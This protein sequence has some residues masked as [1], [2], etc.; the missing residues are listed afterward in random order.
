[1]KKF[2]VPS[3]AVGVQNSDGLV[4][5]SLAE[6]VAALAKRYGRTLSLADLR[7]AYSFDQDVSIA[8]ALSAMRVLGLHGD[9]KKPA[10]I[11]VENLP[12]IAKFKNGVHVV[13]IAQTRR[14]TEFI[15]T[16]K[17]DALSRMKTREFKK[18]F[19]GVTITASLDL[20]DLQRRHT[21]VSQ[22][23]HWFWGRF[24][25]QG[26]NIRAII[27][28]TFV[29]NLLAVGVSLF[30]LQVYDRVIPN[31]SQETL[32]V[33]V[34]GAII[35]ILFEAVLRIARSN[36]V[37]V[38]GRKLENELNETLFKRLVGMKL[39]D[40]PAAPGTLASMIRE[41][42]SVREFFT[43]SSVG[44]VADL[45]F[46][47]VFLGLIYLIAGP[48][49]WVIVA[50]MTA[51]VIPSIL[52]AP[53]MKRLSEEM[54]GGSS[55][56]NRLAIESVYNLENL[57]L[58]RG[59]RFLER[60][61]NEV[62]LLNAE[63]TSNQRHLAARLTFWAAGVQ[64][65]TYVLAVVA[66]V[67]M[68]FAG[69]FTIGAVIAVSILSGRALAPVTQL[70]GIIA[71]WQ[72]TK[73]A[74]TGM[75]MIMTSTQERP[76]DV[77]F[78]RKDVIYG[79]F[80]INN[81]EFAYPHTETPILRVANMTI[82]AGETVGILGMNGSGKSS[83]LRLLSG[84]YVQNSGSLTLD[85]LDMRQID[86]VDLRRDIGLLPQEVSLFRGTLRDNLIL[87][88]NKCSEDKLM[89]ALRFSGLE[90]YLASHPRGIDM[91]IGDGGV[92]LSVG[93]RHSVGLARLYLQD[94]KIVLLD[95]PTSAFDQMLEARIV[96]NL[97]EWTKNKTCILTTH[98][99]QILSITDR[100]AVL[101]SGELT[102]YDARDRVIN[103][104]RSNSSERVA[105]VEAK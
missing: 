81:L 71:R 68:V 105:E 73:T 97:Q 58:Q 62:T 8:Q 27:L 83:L 85:G 63:K 98:R 55:A 23:G 53:R 12:C 19:A 88:G 64:Q 1:M 28:G 101:Q 4:T 7:A 37:D 33:L 82:E 35:A 21:D 5:G 90:Q 84:L 79:N 96:A 47:L 102:A 52:A 26:R 66:G 13:V 2:S 76:A 99:T 80:T 74:L 45:P 87:D 9:F 92:G 93:Q 61:W 36:L 67:Y 34:A 94:P 54:Q 10:T 41:F 69:E 25:N 77:K 32:W 59:E 16:E 11:T 75:E 31:Q 17:P 3:R 30:A 89:E 46:L 29:A 24:R 57:K 39:A 48:V 44:A 43:T 60:Q 42:G 56:A 65:M 14:W 38:A 86:P 70:S 49:V 40:R 50:G 91:E 95:E 104:L 78:A 72:Q 100:L 103:A 20:D 51:I 6:A 18:S 22:K 15:D